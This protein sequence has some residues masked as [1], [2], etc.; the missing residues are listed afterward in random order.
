VRRDRPAN[1]WIAEGGARW[2]TV[3]LANWDDETTRQSVSLAA[4]G[5]T[6]A[7]FNAYDVWRDAPLPDLTDALTA[8]LEPHSCMTVAIR[9]AA[10][11]PQIIGTT[12]HV[13]Q[14]AVDI[15]DEA[16][17]AVT[18]T[19][20]ARSTNLDRRAYGV[21][22]AVPNGMRPATGKPIVPCTVRRF[23]CGHAV[24]EWAAGWD[25]GDVGCEIT[26]RRVGAPAKD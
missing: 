24:L 25:G 7:R 19:L 26:F 4:L 6:G 21:T 12:R 17:D 5:L 22:I 10:A 11:R 14:G 8:M 20:R 15:A 2:W 23:E 1:V 9:P 3:V 13:V 16:W 18:R